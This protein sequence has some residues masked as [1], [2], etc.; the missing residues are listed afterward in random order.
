MIATLTFYP[1]VDR[2]PR[3]RRLEPASAPHVSGRQIVPTVPRQR[4]RIEALP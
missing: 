3:A 4:D 2:S 1:A